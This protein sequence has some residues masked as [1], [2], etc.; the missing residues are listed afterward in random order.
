KGDFRFLKS[1]G[2]I[3]VDTLKIC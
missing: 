1:P 3:K 2:R